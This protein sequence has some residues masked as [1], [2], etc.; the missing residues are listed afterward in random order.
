VAA[1][2][3]R[4]CHSTLLGVLWNLRLIVATCVTVCPPFDSTSARN[5]K[6][7]YTQPLH[8]RLRLKL[9]DPIEKKQINMVEIEGVSFGMNCTQRWS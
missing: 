5:E 7:V 2:S 3:Q 1:H 9:R 6:E 4:A 8:P